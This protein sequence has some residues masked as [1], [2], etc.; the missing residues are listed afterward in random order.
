[1]IDLD[2]NPSSGVLALES[3]QQESVRHALTGQR[4]DSG[5]RFS[6]LTL[7]YTITPQSSHMEQPQ[8]NP[9]S[10]T[11]FKQI[12]GTGRIIFDQCGSDVHDN[13]LGGID[14][15]RVPNILI[16]GQAR[17]RCAVAPS[18]KSGATHCEPFWRHLCF[19]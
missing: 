13:S 15:I 1:M 12:A 10:N 18:L 2:S 3:V 5:M 14:M 11:H 19:S 8:W 16:L 9:P 7:S 4:L 17:C 6:A